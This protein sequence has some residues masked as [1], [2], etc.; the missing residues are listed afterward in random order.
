MARKDSLS[1][2]HEENQAK[3]AG[4]V[5]FASLSSK[6]KNNRMSLAV[7]LENFC[8]EPNGLFL[9]GYKAKH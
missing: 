7:I 6:G 9:A 1:A 8:F 4:A 3:F 2:I 5:K